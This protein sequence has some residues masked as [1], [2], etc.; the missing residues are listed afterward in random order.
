MA[1]VSTTERLARIETQLEGMAKDIAELKIMVPKTME[2]LEKFLSEIVGRY[3][4]IGVYTDMCKKTEY[5][6]DKHEKRIDKLEDDFMKLMTQIKVI[7]AIATIVGP[8]IYYALGKIID[9]WF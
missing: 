8:V 3:V 9:T 2:R 5:E 7:F 4:P 6:L 1:A